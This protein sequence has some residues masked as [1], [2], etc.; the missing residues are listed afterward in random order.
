M[1]IVEAIVSA[2]SETLQGCMMAEL[3]PGTMILSVC[4]GAVE[5]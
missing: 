4:V 2:V 5:M 1:L 3:T